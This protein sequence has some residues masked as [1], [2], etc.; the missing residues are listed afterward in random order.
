MMPL[1]SGDIP[2]VP[3]TCDG[4]GRGRKGVI[5]GSE[6]RGRGCHVKV[7][8]TSP[9]FAHFNCQ[10][11]EKVF[12]SMGMVAISNFDTIKLFILNS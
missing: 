11:V 4:K 10:H 6:I 1:H 8:W 12:F 3:S 9:P 7:R 5:T 2:E